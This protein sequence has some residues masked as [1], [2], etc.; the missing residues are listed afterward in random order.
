MPSLV[1]W[2]GMTPAVTIVCSDTCREVAKGWV[3]GAPSNFCL[4]FCQMFVNFHCYYIEF[5]CIYNGEMVN[6]RNFQC[7][8]NNPT[9]IDTYYKYFFPPSL[10]WFHCLL[11]PCF[12]YPNNLWKTLPKGFFRNAIVSRTAYWSV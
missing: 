8:N 11:H 6:E 9:Q 5:R 1:N 10:H 7:W 3:S 2:K 12:G 4:N